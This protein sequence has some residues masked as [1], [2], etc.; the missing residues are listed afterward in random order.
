M[1]P[2]DM[3]LGCSGP[4]VQM[5]LC[6]DVTHVGFDAAFAVNS[7]GSLEPPKYFPF[8]DLLEP[9]PHP[10]NNSR[11]EM[12]GGVGLQTEGQVAHVA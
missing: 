4:Q 5:Q 6:R 10:P 9:L 11:Q 3:T 12:V 2:R 8:L 1:V 7:D